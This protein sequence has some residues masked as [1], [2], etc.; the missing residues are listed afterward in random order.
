MASFAGHSRPAIVLASVMRP[1][2]LL[3][4]VRE[5]PLD[6]LAAYRTSTSTLLILP[7]KA[8]SPCL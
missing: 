4:P 1:G 6:A 2:A 5:P 8:L 3:K 7:V